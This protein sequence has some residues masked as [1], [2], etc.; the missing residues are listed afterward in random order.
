V[1]VERFSFA[2]LCFLSITGLI[3]VAI[4]IFRNPKL[5]AHP[6]ML[7]AYICLAE[8]CMSFNALV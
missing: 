8:A 4:T 5:Q 2:I 3:F 7:I 6:Q 1:D